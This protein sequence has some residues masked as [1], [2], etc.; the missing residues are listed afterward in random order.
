MQGSCYGVAADANPGKNRNNQSHTYVFEKPSEPFFKRRKQD[1]YSA[2][3]KQR[4]DRRPKCRFRSEERTP[5]RSDGNGTEGRVDRLFLLST[6]LSRR[7]RADPG[8]TS[9]LGIWTSFVYREH[10]RQ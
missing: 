4:S 9:S 6:I 1:E 10:M 7:R 8:A 5:S 3:R 2:P